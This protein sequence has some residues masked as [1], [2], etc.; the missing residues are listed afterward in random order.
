MDVCTLTLLRFSGE[1]KY[2]RAMIRLA[3]V[4]PL[5]IAAAMYK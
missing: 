3:R 1:T 5:L 4:A 2:H